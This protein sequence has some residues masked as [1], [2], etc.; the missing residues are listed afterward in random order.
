MDRSDAPLKWE[1]PPIARL[2]PQAPLKR[3]APEIV[4]NGGR[5][6]LLAYQR[7]GK[8]PRG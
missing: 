8:D 6:D 7:R 2:A 1:G 4:T 5:D 3:P